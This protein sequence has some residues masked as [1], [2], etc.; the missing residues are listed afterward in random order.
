MDSNLRQFATDAEWAQLTAVE[1]HG[2][3]RAAAKALGI[4]SENT[5]RR[6]EKRVERRAAQQGYMPSLGWNRP[7]PAGMRSRGPSIRVGEDGKPMA[8]SWDKIGIAGRD[9]E[10]AVQM[11]EPFVI[12]Q[13]ANNIDEQGNI[14]QQWVTMKPDAEAMKKCFE[15]WIDKLSVKV[16]RVKP[17]KAP[18]NTSADFLPVIPVGDHHTGMHAWEKE[19]GQNYDLKEAKHRLISGTSHLVGLAPRAKQSLLIFLGDFLHYDGHKPV[20]PTSG[21]Q[22]DADSRAAKMIDVGVALMMSTIDL[23][24]ER[25]DSVHVIVEIGNHDLS[26]SI[27]LAAAMK[28]IYRNEPRVTIDTS[29]RHFHYYRFGKTLIGTH[30]G[31]GHKA[32]P[33][34]LPMIMAADRPEDWGA[35]IYRYW[36]TGHVHHSHG[37]MFRNKDYVGCSVESMRVLAPADAF[38]DQNG[39]RS[40]QD[41]KQLIIHAEYGEIA[42]H[43]VNPRMFGQVS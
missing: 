1:E 6:T 13:M 9:P 2:S 38:A 26:N 43:T 4:A 28:Q 18:K 11:P 36:L 22:V 35:T 31:H 25:H 40:W 19:T 27:F 29:P 20:T 37:V 41:M 17:T 3:R 21:H 42:R 5:I 32:K 39:Y 23:A 30:H 33:A 14:R 24:L 8:G 16:H 10:E 34:D 7:I 15:Q 12:K